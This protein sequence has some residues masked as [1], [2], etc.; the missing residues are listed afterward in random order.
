MTKKAA[1]GFAQQVTSREE[2]RSITGNPSELVNNKVITYI[3]RHCR[4]FISKAPF[5]TISTADGSG[6]CD[7]SPR[8][9]APGFVFVLNEKQL[10]IPERPG[11]K[12]MDSL[13]NILEN[14]KIGLLFMIPGLGETLRVNGSAC[15]IRDEELLENMTAAGKRPLLGIG[16]EVEEC[17]IHCAKAFRRSGLWEPG[18]WEPKETLP[19]GAKILA[20]HAKLPNTDE[21]AVEAMLDKSYKENL[22]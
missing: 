14:P 13:Q 1:I 3:D 20:A 7:V 19:K 17:F 12:R 6:F 11:N 18:T 15:I 2:L 22:Y 5:L 10:V 4:E 21:Q 8:G 16:V 9:D